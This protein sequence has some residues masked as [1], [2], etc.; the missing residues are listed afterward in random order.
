MTDPRDATTALVD[1]LVEA[2]AAR[3]GPQ[4]VN[5]ILDALTEAAREADTGPKR[6]LAE[7]LERLK[8]SEERRSKLRDALRSAISQ[9]DALSAELK[10]RGSG[11]AH[12][13]KT[14]RPATGGG[15]GKTRKSRPKGR[16]WTEHDDEKVREMYRGGAGDREIA[17]AL[18]RSLPAV[19]QRRTGKLGLRRRG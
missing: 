15:D 2:A 18:G 13:V 7:A 6:Q 10:S 9:R 19:R 8:E 3:L 1:A 17:E 4:L 12:S 16:P 14:A 5:T 11:R